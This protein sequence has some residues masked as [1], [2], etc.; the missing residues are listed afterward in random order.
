LEKV[1]LNA[2]DLALPPFFSD[3][4]ADRTIADGAEFGE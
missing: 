3:R 2:V 4:T 1:A